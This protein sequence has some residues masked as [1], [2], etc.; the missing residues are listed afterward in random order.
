[1]DVYQYSV[2]CLYYPLMCYVSLFLLPPFHSCL[3]ALLGYGA[4][5][6]LSDA[7][8]CS[9]MY[10]AL[11]NSQLDC[12]DALLKAKPNLTSVTSVSFGTS[13]Y[14]SIVLPCQQFGQSL[15]H[16]A[17][18][19]NVESVLRS[20]LVEMRTN[21]P[22]VADIINRQDQDGYTALHLASSNSCKVCTIHTCIKST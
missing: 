4:E 11:K 10:T 22:L 3:K 8:G 6:D 1:M 17:V 16:A 5:I 15:L 12:V 13:Y 9:P 2:L 14:H 19:C 18:L 21:G 7:K 20:L